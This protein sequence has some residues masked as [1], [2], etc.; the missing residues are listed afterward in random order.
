M[1]VTFCDIQ[2]AIFLMKDLMFHERMKQSMF[3]TTSF[4]KLFACGDVAI[5]E[6]SIHE[7]SSDIMTKTLRVSKFE[8]WLDLVK[9][10]C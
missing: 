1:I 4:M 3:I 7:K 8:H 5:S 10:H 2:S 9:A 6:I